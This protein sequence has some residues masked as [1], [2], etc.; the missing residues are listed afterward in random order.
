MNSDLYKT[1]H[2]RY[3]KSTPGR[4]KGERLN[5][6]KLRPRATSLLFSITIDP[7]LAGLRG[8]REAFGTQRAALHHANRERPFRHA[9]WDL[10][11]EQSEQTKPRFNRN[12]GDT[13]TKGKQ[14][15]ARWLTDSRVCK[16]IFMRPESHDVCEVCEACGTLCSA[17]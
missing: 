12:E 2:R 17:H 7:S 16:F 11:Q 6:T 15:R 5:K 10:V 8:S 13:S 9:A 3:P 1:S 14:S 4:M